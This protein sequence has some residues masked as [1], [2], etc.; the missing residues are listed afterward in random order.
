MFIHRRFE[1]WESPKKMTK[2]CIVARLLSHI[3]IMYSIKCK[4]LSFSAKS[5]KHIFFNYFFT[6]V[7]KVLKSDRFSNK[8][9]LC[10]RYKI[11]IQYQW[12][13]VKMHPLFIFN[14]QIHGDLTDLLKCSCNVTWLRHLSQA[15]KIQSQFC[16]LQTTLDSTSWKLTSNF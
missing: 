12:G 10:K 4:N 14:D 8:M 13:Q 3:K 7:L 15:C 9:I 2:E 11:Y 1:L 5:N 16:K 6:T